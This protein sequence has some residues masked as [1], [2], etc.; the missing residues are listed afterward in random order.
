MNKEALIK[1]LGEYFKTRKDVAFAYLFGSVAKDRVHSESD[2]DIGVYFTPAT[3]A[4][5][6]ESE[7]RY[8]GESEIWGDLEKITERQTDMVVLNRA[9]S[10]L[11]Y[12]I[13]QEGIP[14]AINNEGLNN[15]MYLVISSAAEDYRDFVDDYFKIMQRSNSLSSVDREKLQRMISFIEKDCV[16]F[17][18]FQNTDEMKYKDDRNLRRNIERWAENIVNSSIDIA[19]TLLGSEKRAIPQTYKE[20]LKGLFVLDDF[21]D[22]VAEKLSSFSQTRNIL[23]HEY[24]D[25]RFA[26]LSRFMKEGEPIYSYLIKYAEDVLE[27]DSKPNT[28]K[29]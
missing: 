19:K 20:I 8:P 15:R 3:R 10:T 2:V 13:M 17:K 28:V 26:M 6:Y 5:E 21:D 29:K 4:L 27:K 25:L 12:A 16:D 1:K 18:I 14:L 23:A 22:K 24:L 7:N 9:P 11:F